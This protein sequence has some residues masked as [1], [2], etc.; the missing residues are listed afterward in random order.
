LPDDVHRSGV[1]AES[2]SRVFLAEK[3]KEHNGKIDGPGQ[4]GKRQKP[5]HDFKFFDQQSVLPVR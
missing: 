4:I 5:D 1:P 2:F 3:F